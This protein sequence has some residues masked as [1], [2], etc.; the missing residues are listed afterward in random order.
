[1][2]GTGVNI[3]LR[4][5]ADYTTVYAL[6]SGEA[7]SLMGNICM[8]P[9]THVAEDPLPD[10]TIFV[11]AISDAVLA[12]SR[13]S[14]AGGVAD[15]RTGNVAWE[16]FDR[17]RYEVVCLQEVLPP[18]TSQN[19]ASA[20]G[21]I[22]LSGLGLNALKD[23]IIQALNQASERNSH[24]AC[25]CTEAAHSFGWMGLATS[26]TK[27]L[28]KHMGWV[29]LTLIQTCHVHVVFAMALRTLRAQAPVEAQGRVNYPSSLSGHWRDIW[30]HF[31]QTFDD[32]SWRLRDEL[33]EV[34]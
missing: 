1:M 21:D 18:F 32:V 8:H 22:C 13:A 20:L 34:S 16:I 29:L 26:T 11:P 4:N 9:V 6:A 33:A 14:D 30:R 28:C 25:K 23:H 24:P 17:L 5:L 27:A 7:G 10:L 19:F 2:A 12:Y 15:P 31:P 3:W